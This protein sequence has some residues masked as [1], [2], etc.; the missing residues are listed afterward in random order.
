MLG[1]LAGWP[2]AT[3]LPACL[4]PAS[5]PRHHQP[6][7]CRSYDECLAKYERAAVETQQSLS[8]LNFGQNLIFSTALSAAMLLGMQAGAGGCRRVLAGAGRCRR[9]LAGA[10]GCWRGGRVQAV[11]AGR[12][13]GRGGHAPTL[14]ARSRQGR[15]EPGRGGPACSSGAR[16]AGLLGGR[17]LPQVPP[18][19]PAERCTGAA[20]P[21]PCLLL[22]TA[23][24]AALI[25]RPAA[26]PLP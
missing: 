2:A 21:T 5:C 3:C 19:P 22:P 24:A 23:P 10:G 6:R 8:A 20:Q 4:P 15:G 13:G 12:A 11:L 26:A 25:A 7:A 16:R 17:A 14:C 18:R 9:V 1:R